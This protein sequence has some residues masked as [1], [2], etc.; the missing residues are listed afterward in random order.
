MNLTRT[1]LKKQ[2]DRAV[3]LGWLTFFQEA[4]DTITKGYFDTADLMGIGSRETN[5]DPKWLK[6]K[7]DNGHGCGLMQI[8]DRSFPEF[9]NSVKWQDARLGIL[10]GA[11]VLMSKW[12]DYENNIG[13]RLSVKGNYF[14]AQ[15]ASG[16]TAQ[17]I[18]LSSYNCG[19][20]AQYCF[21]KGINIDK[22]STGKDYGA[23]V[24]QRAAVLRGFINSAAVSLAQTP[25]GDID[26]KAQPSASFQDPAT[27]GT[28]TPPPITQ[29]AD[30]IVNTGDTP[31]GNQQDVNQTATVQ[32]EKYQGVG[33]FAVLKK[34][35]TAVGGGNLSFQAL[36]EYATEASGWP[37]WVIG[38]IS[39]VAIIAAI[40]GISW[41]IFRVGHYLIWALT[42]YWRHKHEADLAA[43]PTKKDVTF[44]AP[45]VVEQKG[46]IR[47]VWGWIW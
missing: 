33:L 14:T 30:T 11:E 27:D 17:H 23:D 29:T 41:L 4:A 21:A 37:P 18:V 16:Q 25:T 42:T 10:K 7:G 1:Q 38:L 19:R 26:E 8:D 34:D 35:F 36:N 3:S 43:D 22:Y 15:A 12:R 2:F 5:L 45:V 40:L 32:L 6:K 20:W 46:L 13:K 47:E 44:Q 24:M 28:A 39:K 9:T 31:S